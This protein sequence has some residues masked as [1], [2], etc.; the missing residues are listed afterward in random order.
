M[1]SVRQ[2]RAHRSGC[3]SLKSTTTPSITL[4]SP[5]PSLVL[6]GWKTEPPLPP[7][8]RR[9]RARSPP[10]HRLPNPANSSALNPSTSSH[11]LRSEPCRGKATLPL[12]R[13][14]DLAGIPPREPLTVVPPLRCISSSLDSHRSSFWVGV[15]VAIVTGSRR[16][17]SWLARTPQHRRT[18]HCRR[19]VLLAR[20]RNPKAHHSVRNHVGST[21]VASASPADSP[22]TG[23]DFT[24][25]RSSS[26]VSVSPTCGSPCQ[27]VQAGATAGHP[28]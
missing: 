7:P 4:T 6:S 20:P 13:H 9:A 8:L 26:P 27:R 19:C 14:G 16:G 17:R 3:E 1:A 18:C 28:T 11:S 24:V 2:P 10:H 12:H 23:D 25:V 15:G 21:R 22:A 5:R